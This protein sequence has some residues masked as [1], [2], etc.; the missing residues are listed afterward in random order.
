MNRLHL[1]A[2]I[3]CLWLPCAAQAWGDEGHE[4]T[5]LIADHYLE[6]GVRARVKLL[7]ATDASGLVGDRGIAAESTWADRY[8]NITQKPAIGTSSTSRRRVL[9]FCHRMDY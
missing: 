2:A 6:P 7:L 8:R 1:A 3:G 4:I 9:T 5:A